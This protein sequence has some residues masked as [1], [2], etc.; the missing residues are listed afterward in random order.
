MDGHTRGEGRNAPHAEFTK[1]QRQSLAR[2]LFMAIRDVHATRSRH[3]QSR[4]SIR[5]TW[6]RI[7]SAT[8]ASV[9]AAW[10]EIGSLSTVWAAESSQGSQKS[11]SD[12]PVQQ[13]SDT[14]A[15]SEPES[16]PKREG[17][18]REP[19]FLPPV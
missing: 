19:R 10:L 17:P 5:G 2:G 9:L 18:P 12:Q 8:F 6:C 15:A 11:E 7:V 14:S 16:E 3:T 1:S 4:H 13:G